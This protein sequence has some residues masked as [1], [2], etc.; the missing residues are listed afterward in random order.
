[1]NKLLEPLQILYKHQQTV[2]FTTETVP[3]IVYKEN[4]IP[5][6]IAEETEQ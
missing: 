4:G 1:V 3:T 2:D 5:A 6:L